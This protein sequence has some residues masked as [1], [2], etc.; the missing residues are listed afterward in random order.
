MHLKTYANRGFLNPT[1]KKKSQVLRGESVWTDSSKK[2]FFV[3]PL[4]LDHTQKVKWYTEWK[5]EV[6][7]RT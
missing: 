4:K 5:P 2:C 1:H 3:N 6:S 7:S